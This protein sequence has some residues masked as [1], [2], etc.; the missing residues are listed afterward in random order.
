MESIENKPLYF[1]TKSENVFYYW[2]KLNGGVTHKTNFDELPKIKPMIIKSTKS[3]LTNPIVYP[4]PSSYTSDYYQIYET[5][6]DINKKTWIPTNTIDT[7]FIFDT[8]DSYHTNCEF[9]NLSILNNI[10]IFVYNPKNLTKSICNLRQN[11]YD[12]HIINCF[13]DESSV[14]FDVVFV[15]DD[16][17]I[18]HYNKNDVDVNDAFFYY[19]IPILFIMIILIG[20]VVIFSK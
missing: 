2:S 13:N 16:H 10:K 20:F 6:F 9:T 15:P 17:L 8:S 19:V 14:I 4:L 18:E 11:E 12:K 7:Y 1:R 5:E 3:S